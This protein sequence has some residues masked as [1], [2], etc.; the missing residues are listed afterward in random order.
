M[1]CFPSVVSTCLQADKLPYWYVL[2]LLT[3]DNRHYWQLLLSS[4]Q[5][6]RQLHKISC[7]LCLQQSIP[8][9]L[10]GLITDPPIAKP[11]LH[12]YVHTTSQCWLE[13][14]HHASE[15]HCDDIYAERMMWPQTRRTCCSLSQPVANLYT[16]YNWT[17]R[18]LL[19]Q[20]QIWKVVPLLYQLFG[21]LTIY[22]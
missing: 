17:L 1:Y 5:S 6:A 20:A 15:G 2:S 19:L 9:R 10:S 3:T 4:H 7:L 13:A 12:T 21:E 18:I 22:I 11:H 16:W 8:F 14:V